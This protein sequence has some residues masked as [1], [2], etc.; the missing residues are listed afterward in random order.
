MRSDAAQRRATIVREARRLFAAFGGGIPLE[1]VAEASGVGIATLYRNFESRAALTDAVALAILADMQAAA[2][3]G[4]VAMTDD[5]ATAWHGFVARLVELDLGALTDALA[6][7]V[8]DDLSGPVRDAQ[9]ETLARVEEVLAAAKAAGIVRADLDAL[10][11]VL[12]IGMVTRPQPAAIRAAR[13]QLVPRLVEILE[14][15]MRA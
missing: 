14:A 15:G 13:P 5:P 12:A 6:H 2:A 3:D 4:L 8:A 1:S 11:L 10:E 7:H 9:V